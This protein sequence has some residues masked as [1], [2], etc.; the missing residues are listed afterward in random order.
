MIADTFGI[1]DKFIFLHPALH[2]AMSGTNAFKQG[3]ELRG[4]VEVFQVTQFVKHDI[5]LQLLWDAHQV[6]V[7]VDVSL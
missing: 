4:V 7:E 3:V 2:L 1:S 6:Q 5:V